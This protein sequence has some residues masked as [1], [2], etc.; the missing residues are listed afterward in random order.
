MNRS[1][2]ADPPS[3]LVGG[4]GSSPGSIGVPPSL[5]GDVM[6]VAEVA[7][8]LRVGRSQIYALA[9][10]NEIPLRRVGKHLRFSRSALVRW[11]ASCGPP[12]VQEGH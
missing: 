4:A 3:P 5:E 9:A 1:R 8:F 7:A 12:S 2:H 10:R 11:L 6:N